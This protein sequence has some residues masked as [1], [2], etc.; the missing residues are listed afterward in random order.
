MNEQ[1]TATRTDEEIAADLR[2]ALLK[3]SKHELT[4]KK[5]RVEISG[6]LARIVD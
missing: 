2:D 5:K 1:S 3:R 4:D 6:E